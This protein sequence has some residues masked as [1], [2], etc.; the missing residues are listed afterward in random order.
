M[1]KN[2]KMT[3][4]VKFQ[5]YAGASNVLNH[6]SWGLGNTNI[7][8]TT[9]GVAGAPGGSRAINLRGTLSF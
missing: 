7:F 9:F 2:F 1:L 6:P 8:S 3:E 5:L 4:R